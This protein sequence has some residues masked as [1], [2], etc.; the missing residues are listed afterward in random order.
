M[1]RR[2]RHRENNLVG[3]TGERLGGNK[4]GLDPIANQKEAAFM[5]GRLLRYLITGRLR[6]RNPIALLLMSGIGILLLMPFIGWFDENNQL[7]LRLPQDGAGREI[8]IL[9]F[10]MAGVLLLY[11]VIMSVLER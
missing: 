3:Y 10:A 4:S 11:S 2:K 1:S 7:G 8:F 5:E 6:T 9:L